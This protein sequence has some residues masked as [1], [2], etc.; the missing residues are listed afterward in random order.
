MCARLQS[1]AVLL[2]SVC[3]TVIDTERASSNSACFL[4]IRLTK[5]SSAS[6]SQVSVTCCITVV[7]VFIRVCAPADDQVCHANCTKAF[8]IRK[9]EREHSPFYYWARSLCASVVCSIS[10]SRLTK[11]CTTSS[12]WSV[13]H[14]RL[15]RRYNALHFRCEY[16]SLQS[17]ILIRT[18]ASA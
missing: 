3:T 1:V 17:L 15:S 5:H 9:F 14:F 7:A 2:A 18:L 11:S 6:A 16:I 13:A 10:L 12:Q 4:V 8:P